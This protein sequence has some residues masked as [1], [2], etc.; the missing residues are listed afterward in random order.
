MGS[1][2]LSF[3][4]STAQDLCLQS[5]ESGL[6]AHSTSRAD[7]VTLSNLAVMEGNNRTVVFTLTNGTA[8]D[9]AINNFARGAASFAGTG[10]SSDSFANAV[11]DQE[12]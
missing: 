6:A 8:S 7:G 4:I 5:L 9:V 2:S 11:I 1:V 10:D 3:G 12:N